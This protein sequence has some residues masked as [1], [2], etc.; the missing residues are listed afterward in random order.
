[1]AEVFNQQQLL[2]ML[3]DDEQLY[4]RFVE[5][6]LRLMDES[7]VRLEQHV[8][9]QNWQ[10]MVKELH[11]LKGMALQISATALSEQSDQLHQMALEQDARIQNLMPELRDCVTQTRRFIM[12]N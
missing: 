12:Q 11:S 6:F 2:A 5:K 7:L 4:R 1:M 9:E 3:G 10:A 8:V